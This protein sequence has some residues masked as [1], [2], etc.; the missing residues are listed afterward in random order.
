[1]ITR[2]IKV[3]GRMGVLLGSYIMYRRIIQY[4][5]VDALTGQNLLAPVLYGGYL[6]LGFASFMWSTNVGYSALQWFMTSQTLVFCY[7]FIKSL[8]LL[9][10]Y[11]PGHPTRLYNLLGNSSF[12]LLLIFVI[13]MWTAPDVF[14]RMTHGGEEARL[15]GYLMNPNELGMLAGIG[16]AGLLFDLKRDHKRGWTIFK[17]IILFYALYATGSRSSLIGALLIIGFH[18]RQS[19]NKKLKALIFAGMLLVTPVAVHKVILKDG[20]TSRLEEIMSMTGRLPFWKAL[21]NEGLP[22]EP[23]LGFGFMRIDYKEYFQSAHTYPGKM[24]HNTFMQVLMNLGFV[25]ITIVTFQM[26]FT[27]RGIFRENEEKKL[28]LLSLLIPLIIN[29][30]TEFG[31]F[32]ESNYGI[33]FYQLVIV[34]ICFKRG[35]AL[36]P[37]QRI[38]LMK[39]RPELHLTAGTDS[40]QMT[41]IPY[42]G[43]I[44]IVKTQ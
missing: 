10:E 27:F 3:V 38:H 26:I 14:F 17:L 6:L 44:N 32:G 24:T 42:S 16:V 41:A 40:T 37:K 33:L 5:A 21:I 28:M 15:G 2:A 7:F 11:F 30:L 36:T 29:S 34:Y 22:R 18:V 8:Y 9:D 20:D 1:M 31:I 39:R 23:L 25:G 35:P 19:S 4:G 43:N 13:G 12:A